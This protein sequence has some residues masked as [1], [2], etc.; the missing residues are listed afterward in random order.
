MR[1]ERQAQSARTQRERIN[2]AQ[3]ISG[4]SRRV[5][6]HHVNVSIVTCINIA[7]N[8][9]DDYRK[10]PDLRSCASRKVYLRGVFP[11]PDAIFNFLLAVDPSVLDKLQLRGPTKIFGDLPNTASNY[12]PLKCAIYERQYA[13]LGIQ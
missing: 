10:I 11:L 8:L 9:D 13:F 1:R 6:Q 3:S 4:E 2:T 7:D 12:L 5:M